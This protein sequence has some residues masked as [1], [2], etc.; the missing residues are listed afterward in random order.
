[1]IIN[2]KINSCISLWR[3]CL[4]LIVS[5]LLLYKSHP[6]LFC[7]RF[8]SLSPSLVPSSLS[9]PISRSSLSPAFGSAGLLWAPLT[10]SSVVLERPFALAARPAGGAAVTDLSPLCM[11]GIGAQRAFAR[12]STRSDICNLFSLCVLMSYSEKW[13]SQTF[14][15]NHFSD[16]FIQMRQTIEALTSVKWQ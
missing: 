5:F 12:P 14:T 3:A 8:L 13:D 16:S 6:S 9:L 15:F 1:M 11:L 10:H 4:F 2:C 7:S